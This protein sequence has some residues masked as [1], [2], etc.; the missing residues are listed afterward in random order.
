VSHRRWPR[1]QGRRSQ[2]EL[3]WARKRVIELGQ[4]RRRLARAIVSGAIPEDLALEETT[5]HRSRAEAGYRIQ[6]TAEMICASIEDILTTALWYVTRVDEVY[7]FGGHRSSRRWA[8]CW[9]A[10]RHVRGEGVDRNAMRYALDSNQ[11]GLVLRRRRISPA[12]SPIGVSGRQKG[13]D[14]YGRVPRL[15]LRSC[16]GVLMR[17]AR[18]CITNGVSGCWKVARLPRHGSG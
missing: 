5:P 9:S 1:R 12:V 10:R 7:R 14:N 4:E 16:P 6:N 15:V 18:R 2:P 3:A 8:S 17:S 13:T 11:V